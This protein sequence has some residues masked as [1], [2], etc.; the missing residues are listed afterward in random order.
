MGLDLITSEGRQNRL[1]KADPALAPESARSLLSAAASTITPYSNWITP[2]VE[3][4]RFDAVFF[5]AV[6]Q[7]N[8]FAES[9]IITTNAA[10]V[11]AHRW[12][13]PA[14]ALHLHAD[15]SAMFTLPP[16]TYVTMHHLSTFDS[17]ESIMAWLK[18]RNAAALQQAPDRSEYLP[19][20]EPLVDFEPSRVVMTLP[21]PGCT[22]FAPGEHKLP[23]SIGARGTKE[24][25][26][27]LRI[28]GA[29]L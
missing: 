24:E 19:R 8:A 28:P 1:V 14:E 25:H 6:V 22:H 15:L 11:S 26:L 23:V 20:I 12:V 13:S 16:P 21:V 9:G 17:V 29:K 2:A 7:P 18:E 5:V 27:F 4:K 10:E 3:R